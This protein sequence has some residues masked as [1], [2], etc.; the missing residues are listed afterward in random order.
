M[1]LH[2][3]RPG[4]TIAILVGRNGMQST[5]FALCT[6]NASGLKCGS[7][8]RESEDH[9]KFP[10]T[11]TCLDLSDQ[12]DE[13]L[14]WPVEGRVTGCQEQIRPTVPSA[15]SCLT[16]QA[17]LFSYLCSLLTTL[18]ATVS[19]LHAGGKH[20]RLLQALSLQLPTLQWR[21]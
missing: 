7:L 21:V 2:L 10:P 8:T 15:R 6:G 11:S 1:L 16:S 12:V 13:E 20:E 17:S 19:S 4:R 5:H 14:M 3:P 9:S 18:V